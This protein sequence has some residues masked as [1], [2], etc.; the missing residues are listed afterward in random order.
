MFARS[1][2]RRF[3][4]I[5][6]GIQQR[7]LDVTPALMMCEARLRGGS[8]VPPHQHPHEQISYVVSGRLRV[9]I[10]GHEA[11]LE[12][13]DAYAIPGNAM[14]EIEV[15]EDAVVVDVFSPHRSEYALERFIVERP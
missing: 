5:L 2:Y 13:G 12:T 1:R 9:R 7:T 6:P 3:E 11:Q 14:H 10:G 4:E 15:L 8:L